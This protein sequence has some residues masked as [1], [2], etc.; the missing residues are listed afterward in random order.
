MDEAASAL[1]LEIESEPTE[2]DH[3][4][5]E[6]LKLEIEKRVSEKRKRERKY[7]TA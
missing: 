7:K 1:R 6:I 5:E 2:L 4:H 3:L